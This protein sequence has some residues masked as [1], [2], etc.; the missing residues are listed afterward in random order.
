MIKKIELIA[1]AAVCAVLLISPNASASA[2]GFKA[3][4][5]AD[6]II[7]ILGKGALKGISGPDKDV[8]EFLTAPNPYPSFERYL[9][10]IS[11]RDGLLKVVAVGKDIDTNDFGESVKDSFEQVATSLTKTYGSG[12]QVVPIQAAPAQV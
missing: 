3:G 9:C 8:Y 11:P 12:V 1:A 4:M 7:A 6:R 5:T 2:F 10:F